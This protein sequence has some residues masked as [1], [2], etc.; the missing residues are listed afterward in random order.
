MRRCPTC[1]RVL[2]DSAAIFCP[3]DGT[4]LLDTI[5]NPDALADTLEV[6]NESEHNP[7][8]PL[9]EKAAEIAR[10][11]EYKERLSALRNTD[12]GVE[13]VKRELQDL[14]NYV[15]NKVDSITH[16]QPTIE[17]IF[18]Q[19]TDH[20]AVIVS[21]EY[22]VIMSWKQNYANSLSNSSF[23][24]VEQK[25]FISHNEDGELNRIRFDFH[26]N[27]D[28]K[29][30]WKEREGDRFITTEKLGQECIGRLF[31]LMSTSKE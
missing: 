2:L 11:Q 29:L 26:M 10:K 9:L 16:N 8:D 19:N 5:I 23:H 7:S 14:F 13:L 4:P 6:D 21:S 22:F 31:H 27:S 12:Q 17:I 1:R 15:R 25:R 24:I 28:L 20:E 18:K 30:G 3:Y